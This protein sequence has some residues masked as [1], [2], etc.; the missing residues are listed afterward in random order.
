MLRFLLILLK[1]CLFL[2]FVGIGSAG[3][4]LYYY[5][6]DLP[7]Y[8][9]LKAYHPP[10]VTRI[11]SSDGKLIEEYSK[12]NRVFVPITSLPQSLIEAFIA[13]EDKN[14]YSHPGIDLMGIVRASINNIPKMMNNHRLEGASTITQQVV[15]NF[16]LTSQRSLDRKIKEAILSY[17]ISQTLSKDEILELYLN[18]I[19]LGKGAYGVAAAASTYFNKS[20]EELTLNESAILAGLPKAPEGR[21]NPYRS[22]DHAFERKNYVIK[23]MYEDGY[24]TEKEALTAS[25]E[26]IVLI[27]RNKLETVD[28]DYY[29]EQVREEVVN[30][31]GS[32]YFYTAGLTI[33]T[34]LDS[35]A[36]QAAE[37][38]LVNGIIDFDRKKGY[39]GPWRKIDLNA[40]KEEEKDSSKKATNSAKE[41]KG[42]NRPHWQK[43]LENILIPAGLRSDVLAIV[44][45]VEDKSAA[46][47]FKD[48]SRSSLSID[49]M[50]WTK[51]ALKSVKQILNPG[52]I[53]PVSKIAINATLKKDSTKDGKS[54][55]SSSYKY[56]LSQIPQL[57][58]GFILMEHAT[59]KVLAMQG[60]YDFDASKFNRVTQAQRQIG[61]L[62]KTF[63]YLSGLENGIQ[64]NDIFEDSPIEVSQGRG[65][66]MWRPKNWDDKFL[67]RIT[68]RKALEKSRNTVT[69]RIGLKIGLKKIAETVRRFGINDN[70][71]NVNSILLGAIE[72]TLEK[73]TTAFAIIANS[74]KKITPHY[75]ELIQDRKG[76]IIYRRDARDGI[77]CKDYSHDHKGNIMPPEIAAEEGEAITDAATSYQMVSMLHGVTLRGTATS[78]ASLGKIIAGKTGT[79][80]DAKDT[81]FVGFTPQIITGIFIGYD[82]PRSLG[83]KAYGANV[84]LPI[85]KNFFNDV[86]KDAPNLDFIVPS[87]IKL[88]QVDYDTGS[89]SIGGKGTIMEAFKVNS[90]KP[91]LSEQGKG[92]SYE[93]DVFMKIEDLDTSEEIY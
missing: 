9:Q 40:A 55:D 58:G 28:A 76:N 36:Q 22:Y 65:M 17:R 71:M 79:T 81:W 43:E 53:I 77:E 25:K 27:R 16:L 33:I 51:T 74:G 83:K 78:L 30:M 13:A 8:S 34:C 18:Q 87:S 56:I 91:A 62:V 4:V 64:P 92:Q 90:S 88:M 93:E 66:P 6:K 44:L 10:C 73:V 12:E 41:D 21:F 52:D 57:N 29:A 48:G 23:R 60:G 49:D 19:Y 5:S 89:L 85:F 2:G 14:Y 7:D 54:Q 72:S 3:Y 31:F 86:Y 1:I 35:K 68:F 67:G 26:P 82:Q 38:A 75:I 15:K 39:R 80:N 59:G 63:V 69:V 24:I 70:P 50:K 20:V 45:E 37:K 32:E 47:G 11:Y 46:I 42:G 61:S 84:P